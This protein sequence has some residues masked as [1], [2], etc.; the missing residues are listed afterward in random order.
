MLWIKLAVN[1][2][3]NPKVIGLS[4]DAFRV[5]VCGLLYAQQH[6]TDGK[7]PPA[8]IKTFGA[9]SPTKAA[10]EL[11]KAGLWDK[12]DDGWA[13]HDYLEHQRS[14]ADVADLSEKRRKAGAKGG[15]PKA[16]R[17]QVAKQNGSPLPADHR[18]QIT[19]QSVVHTG[20]PNPGSARDAPESCSQPVDEFP[21]LAWLA[22]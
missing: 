22:P 3:D 12:T 16:N 1:F 13:I 21:D 8:A 9:S 5:S 14:K 10:G 20:D 4:S 15:K 7:V 11:V 17:Q 6:L 2:K 18:S 19:H